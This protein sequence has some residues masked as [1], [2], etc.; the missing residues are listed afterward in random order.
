MEEWDQYTSIGDQSGSTHVRDEMPPK[1]DYIT[2]CV[3][4]LYREGPRITARAQKR[5][6]PPYVAQEVGRLA[7]KRAARDVGGARHARLDHVQIRK[8]RVRG[9]K[10][11]D[12]VRELRDR[13][14]HAHI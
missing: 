2:L 7:L 6:R 13:V 9:S 5:P 14:G 3:C 8:V 4:S 12:Q 1:D 11:G 10:G